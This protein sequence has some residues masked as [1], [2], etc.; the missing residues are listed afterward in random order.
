MYFVR[1][2]VVLLV[3]ATALAQPIDTKTVDRI[4][5]ATLKAWNIPGAAVVIVQ[6]DRVVYAQGYGVKEVGGTSPVTADTLFQLAS[7]SKAFTSAAL[8]VLAG[9]GKLAFDDPVRKHVEYFRLSDP[10]ADANVTLRDIV[11]H[12]TGLSRHDA[13]WDDTTLTREEVVRSMASITPSKPFRTTYQYQNILFI[14]AGEAIAHA[15]GM[16]WD[17]FMKARIFQ[18]LGMTRTVIS[19]ADWSAAD[20]A[21]GHRY[22]WRSGAVTPRSSANTTTIGAAG[23][24]K[25]SARDMGNWL[26]FQLAN[27]TFDGKQIADPVQ[28]AETK[29]PHTVMRMEGLSLELHPETHV[30]S[31][32]MG[33]NIQ[34]YR[35]EQLVSHGGA[36][37]GFRTRVSLLPKRNAGLAVMINAERG[38]SLLALQN[39]IT[40]LLTGKPARD[41]NEHY[42]SVDRRSEEKSEK[43]RQERLSRR[44]PDTT[45]SRP[46][47]DYAGEYENAAYGIATI[48]LVDGALMLQWNRVV[49]PLTHFHYDVFR[50]ESAER[51]LDETVAFTLDTERKI[52]SFSLFGERFTRK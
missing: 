39:T 42:L 9:D 11:T 41:W 13:L 21:S 3:A 27:G 23:A 7:T 45:P 48:S 6:N 43:D 31:Y 17:S 33:W 24:I 2:V 4:M 5:T 19:D 44:I 40:D 47:A 10:C 50:A 18:P 52:R 22:D 49:A 8:A 14:A 16:S 46:L 32:G 15:S 28:L 34:D 51:D 1:L 20:H 38:Y 25:S 30:M 37:N 36:L 35:G 29:T 26:R 12:R